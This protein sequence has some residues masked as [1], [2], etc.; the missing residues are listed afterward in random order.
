MRELKTVVVEQLLQDQEVWVRIPP[1]AGL[2]PPFIFVYISQHRIV[3][4]P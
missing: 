4:F 1:R 2:F 3:M